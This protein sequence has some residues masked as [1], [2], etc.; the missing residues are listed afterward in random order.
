MAVAARYWR[1]VPGMV[2]DGPAADGGQAR[3]HQTGLDGPVHRPRNMDH[4]LGVGRGGRSAQPGRLQPAL[5]GGGVGHHPPR[6][7][8]LRG[9]APEDLPRSGGAAERHMGRL[10]GAAHHVDGLGLR[11][12]VP[13][14]LQPGGRAV[15]QERLA[16]MQRRPPGRG[17]PARLR[18]RQECA[19]PVEQPQ[20][21]R[22]PAQVQVCRVQGAADAGTHAGASD[23]AYAVAADTGADPADPADRANPAAANGCARR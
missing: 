7:Q 5:Q 12:V 1:R 17:L 4:A 22:R 13:A 19:E 3:P 16:Q 6:V 21:D 23:T 10:P 18:A 14:V 15:R 20:P 9:P 8:R 11:Q 2:P